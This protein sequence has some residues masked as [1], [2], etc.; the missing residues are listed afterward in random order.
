[1]PESPENDF[2]KIIESA[3]AVATETGAKGNVESQIQPLAFGLKEI[4]ILAMY[5]MTDDFDSDSVAKKMNEIEN[6]DSAEVLKMDLA[7]G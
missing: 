7:L 2:D 5:E 6:V 1:M 4:H 3:K